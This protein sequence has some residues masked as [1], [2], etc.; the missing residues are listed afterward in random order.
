MLVIIPADLIDIEV[1]GLLSVLHRFRRAIGWSIV[2]II[3]ILPGLCTN[4]I[5]L[6]PEYILSIKHQFLL[7]PP[8]QEVVKKEIIK[9]LDSFVVYRITDSKWISLVKYVL[10]KLGFTI[11]PNE[12]NELVLIRLGMG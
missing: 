9:W 8:M 12:K 7:N 1:E 11:V 4:K 3:G 2:D 5:Q 6:E 10:E